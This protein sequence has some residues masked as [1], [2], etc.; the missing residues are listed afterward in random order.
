MCSCPYYSGAEYR[1][2][3]T[4]EADSPVSGTINVK[5]RVLEVF[6]PITISPVLKVALATESLSIALPS[7][8]VLKVYD[9]RYANDLREFY[10]AP[11]LSEE[12]EEAFRAWAPSGSGLRRTLEEWKEKRRAD[13]ELDIEPSAEETEAYLATPLAS[14]YENEVRVY[15]H[16]VSMQGNEIPRFFGRTRFIIE[17]HNAQPDRMTD[18]EVPGILVEYME[19]T[20]LDNLS[21]DALSPALCQKCVDIVLAFGDNGVLNQDV[22]LENFIVPSSPGILPSGSENR[23]RDLV[24]ID[25][26]QS[27]LRREDED[28]EQWKREK[29]STDEEGAIGYVLQTKCG[30]DYK[31]TYRYMVLVEE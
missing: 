18:A 7:T 22:R 14:Y 11:E 17:S 23:R 2:Q 24:M 8:L 21:I 31:P 20:R 4:P 29:W 13:D 15:E 27:R 9:R 10:D 3:I 16:M 26:A 30:W 19:G 12:S 25:F 5:V 28:D 1:L 6:E